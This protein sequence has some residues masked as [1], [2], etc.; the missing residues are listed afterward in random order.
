MRHPSRRLHYES[1]PPPNTLQCIICGSDARFS[2]AKRFDTHRLG[3]VDYWRC[4]ACGFTQS[5]THADMTGAT[6][7]ALNAASHAAYQGTDADPGD[8]RWR[9]RLEAQA[10]VLDDAASH[11]LLDAEGRW[12]DYACG[13][14]KLADGLANNHGRTLLK[15]DRY[16]G[17]ATGYLRE[18]ALAPGGFDLVIT[19]SVF[20]HLMHRADFD[21]IHGLVS[22][23]GVL[24]I[25]TLVCET[26]PDDP[27]WFYLVPVHCA[28]HTNRSMQVLFEQWGYTCSVYSVAAQLWLWFRTDPAA[29]EH[30]VSGANA[31]AEDQPKYL[32]KRGFVDYWK[33]SPLL[34][35]GGA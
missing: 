23:S 21:A 34:R 6:W 5:R 31:R 7:E 11:G 35:A 14:G 13:D 27:S 17:R 28:F 19:T 9:T 15:Y 22:P 4:E 8:P 24:G 18:G 1:M 32:F 26:V 20:E 3:T 33:G 29:I 12:L 25:H 16:M 2:F 30:I 10:R